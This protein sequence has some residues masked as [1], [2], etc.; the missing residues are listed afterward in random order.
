MRR[1]NLASGDILFRK[2]DEAGDAY[3]IVQGEI[4]ISAST[5]TVTLQKGE[6]FGESGLIGNPRM[7]TATAQGN[8]RLIVFA[9]DEFRQAI[10]TEP[11]TAEMLIEVL[12]RRLAHTVDQ[13]ENVRS[14][15]G[16]WLRSQ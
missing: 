14:P 15:A 7:A 3:L 12:I 8:C 16:T 4:V 5:M 2:G 11:K 9:A 13:L 10:L 6:L 1:I